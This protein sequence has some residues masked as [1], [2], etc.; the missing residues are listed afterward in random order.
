M[1]ESKLKDHRIKQLHLELND[2]LAEIALLFKPG[3]K[4]TL[5]ARTPGIPDRD[6]LVGDDSD[7]EA[8]IASIQRLRT[9]EAE[10]I[11]EKLF[12]GGKGTD[13]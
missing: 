5:V 7:L 8:L 12:R 9:Q 10:E 2:A 6:V 13:G 4:L 3:V 11:S 1:A